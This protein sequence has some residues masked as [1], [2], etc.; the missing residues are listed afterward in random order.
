M[1]LRYLRYGLDN[2]KTN[3]RML[4]K[5]SMK[6]S[7]HVSSPQGE[8]R[9]GFPDTAGASLT[10]PQI[11]SKVMV[12]YQSYFMYGP[13]TA[14]NGDLIPGDADSGCTCADCETNEGLSMRWRTRYDD[15]KFQ[16]KSWED[17]QY[18]LCPPRVLGYIL[19][20]KQ[21]AQLQ[22]D[23]LSKVPIFDDKQKDTS[24]WSNRL[25]LADDDTKGFLLD[26][27]KSHVSSSDHRDQ[28]PRKALEIDDMISQKGK[29]LIILL[30]GKIRA[31][32]QGWDRGA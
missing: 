4:A 11:E 27:V 2:R 9:N 30:Y 8:K 12:D 29:G 1:D 14:L 28:R 6:R 24:A 18:M 20:Q 13:A 23:L 10:F 22:V 15:F 31:R 3:A 17:E 7:S 19:K 32:S 25:Q 26:L 5:S 16:M 21:W